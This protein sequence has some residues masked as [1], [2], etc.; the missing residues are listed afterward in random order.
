VVGVVVVGVIDSTGAGG[1]TS[2]SISVPAGLGPTPVSINS[3]HA[4]VAA[5]TTSVAKPPSRITTKS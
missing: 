3:P 2:P 4:A 1:G 5:P